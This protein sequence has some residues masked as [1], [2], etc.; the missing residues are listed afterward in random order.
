MKKCA[1]FGML[2][3]LV[4]STVPSY[5]FIDYLFSGSASRDAIGNS[6]L[7]DFRAWWTGNP[8]YTFNP[9]WSGNRTNQQQGRQ[10]NPT[11]PASTQ[12]YSPMGA[13]SPGMS[14]TPQP[15]VTYYPQQVP[16]GA[17]GRSVTQPAQPA[18]GGA[19]QQYQ[20]RPQQYQYQANP[21]QY[22]AGPQQY[23]YQANTQQYQARPRQYQGGAQY[24]QASPQPQQYPAQSAYQPAPQSYQRA[25]QQPALP[26]AYPTGA[27][28][29]QRGP[30]GYPS[31]VQ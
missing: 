14:P 15:T 17:Y 25:A 13:A 1:L 22:Q 7:G 20:A 23:Q 8:G 28:Q 24:Y 19:P 21:R 18:Y 26:Q 6:V 10:A 27:Q 11:N 3:F 12:R 5:G 9:F 4:A 2:L 29:Y 30:S 16:Q 31:G